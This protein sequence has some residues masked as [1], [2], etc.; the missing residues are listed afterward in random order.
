MKSLGSKGHLSVP[1]LA[2][3]DSQP[4]PVVGGM[5]SGKLQ[6]RIILNLESRLWGVS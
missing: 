5:Q 3:A 6:A 2:P 4:D 1:M